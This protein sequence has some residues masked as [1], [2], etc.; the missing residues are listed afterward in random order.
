MNFSKKSY[1]QNYNYNQ[2]KTF[3]SLNV[4]KSCIKNSSYK[5]LSKFKINNN[6]KNI[7]QFFKHSKRNYF[8][9]DQDQNGSNNK[10][11]FDE[12]NE[13]QSDQNQNCKKLNSVSEIEELNLTDLIAEANSNS[14]NGIME[15][16]SVMKNSIQKL[17]EIKRIKKVTFD[18]LSSDG[19]SHK[20]SFKFC[21]SFDL[22]NKPFKFEG[23]GASKKNAKSVASLKALYFLN[24][25]PQFFSMFDSI[26]VGNLIKHEMKSILSLTENIENYFLEVLDQSQKEFL[27]NENILKTKELKNENNTLKISK[28]ITDCD[29]KIKEILASKNSLI[30]LNHLVQGCKFEL[31]SEEGSSH[32]KLFKIEL[33]I[34]KASLEDLKT[35]KSSFVKNSLLGSLSSLF[36]SNSVLIS[37]NESDLIFYG[38]GNSKKQ[39]KSKAAQLAIESIFNIKI[40]P[41]GKKLIF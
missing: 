5:K 25:I 7:N 10:R 40:T 37:S 16:S 39:A 26:Y 35:S 23:E 33:K 18:M 34:S 6:N 1:F 30:I 17:Y 14:S 27:E 21:L 22:N 38:S 9:M 3:T 36:E 32:A 29:G 24:C 11:T 20:P 8:K 31:K 19:P 13:G 2:C 15:E 4:T 28:S 41:D 12:M